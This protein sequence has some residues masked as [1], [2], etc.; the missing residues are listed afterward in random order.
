MTDSE[1]EKAKKYDRY[2]KHIASIEEFGVWGELN[3]IYPKLEVIKTWFENDKPQRITWDNWKKLDELLS[4]GAW[5][6]RKT[7]HLTFRIS[8][9]LFDLIEN[10]LKLSTKL[11]LS[12]FLREAI[13]EKIMCDEPK[14]YIKS[15]Q[16]FQKVL[17]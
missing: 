8:I 12:E 17:E 6:K 5:M 3:K 4:Q 14:L 1:K 10:Y 2:V 16:G 15:F 7:R 13:L 9:P 11:N